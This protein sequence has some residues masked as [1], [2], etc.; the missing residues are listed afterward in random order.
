MYFD[1]I[2][3]LRPF[4]NYHA[5]P[6]FLSIS[7]SP[8]PINLAS[9]LK[10]CF[11]ILCQELPTLIPTIFPHYFKIIHRPH[12]CYSTFTIL[13]T[14]SDLTDLHSLQYIVIFHL[15]SQKNPA[16]NHA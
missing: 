15:G 6:S 8:Q 5:L 11:V 4:P 10:N 13:Q 3:P 12:L 7:T 9:L 16:P 1:F 14:L 2:L